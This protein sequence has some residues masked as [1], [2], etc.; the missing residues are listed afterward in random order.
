MYW[1]PRQFALTLPLA[2][3]AEGVRRQRFD[4]G[5]NGVFYSSDR[6]ASLDD[7]RDLLVENDASMQWEEFRP[8]L[9][10]FGRK[11]D[12]ARKLRAGRTPWEVIVMFKTLVLGAL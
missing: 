12:A 7:K 1:A 5:A 11:P 4:D 10:R 8:T 6:Y 3:K 9:E 2:E